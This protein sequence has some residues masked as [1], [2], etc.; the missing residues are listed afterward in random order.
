[1]SK[2][3]AF[4]LL[5][6]GGVS[7]AKSWSEAN[8][9]RYNANKINATKNYDAP[10]MTGELPAE[11][12]FFK[13]AQNATGKRKRTDDDC[14][15]RR[16]KKVEGSEHEKPQSEDPILTTHRVK[17]K[18]ANVPTSISSFKELRKYSIPAH[19]YPNL[20]SSG[21]QSPTAIQSHCIPILLEASLWFLSRYFCIL[22]VSF[23]GRN[24]VAISPTGTG[25][26]LAYL[27]PI[28]A[29]L[30]R[31]ATSGTT[32]A[33]VRALVIVPTRELAH[34]I[35]NECL[36]LAQ[37]RKWNVVLFSKATANALSMKAARD[38]VGQDLRVSSLTKII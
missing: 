21:Y 10:A 14:R 36:K 38:K 33:G 22:M 28:F 24:L 35:H 12:D 27:L 34:Q 31:P 4:H 6:R 1:M 9:F 13:Y 23:Q 3:E 7:L 19:L 37:G 30:S 29:K 17:T 18:G 2:N 16:R 32:E 15:A 25:K 11:L 26:T 5:S 20:A 8:L